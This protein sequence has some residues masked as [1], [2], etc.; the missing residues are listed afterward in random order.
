MVLY[1]IRTETSNQMH[2]FIKKCL[3]CSIFKHN[4]ASV[5]VDFS[6]M[7][8]VES[9]PAGHLKRN[10]VFIL[11]LISLKTFSEICSLLNTFWYIKTPTAIQPTNL[12]PSWCRWLFHLLPVAIMIC[13][14]LKWSFYQMFNHLRMWYKWVFIYFHC[15]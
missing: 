9:P 11:H 5:Q 2:K 15:Y 8:P 7:E 1:Y 14:L 6:L 10:A 13:T 4:K 12:T 3:L